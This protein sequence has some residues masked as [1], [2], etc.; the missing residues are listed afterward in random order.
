[1]KIDVNKE[2]FGNH[3]NFDDPIKFCAMNRKVLWLVRKI[4]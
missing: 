4:C 2:I 1:M 3:L